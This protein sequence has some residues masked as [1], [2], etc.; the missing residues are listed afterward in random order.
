MARVEKT[1]QITLGEKT[2]NAV[3]A[4]TS[5]EKQALKGFANL[6]FQDDKGATLSFFSDLQIISKKDGTL[7]VNEPAKNTKND[8]G[9]WESHKYYLLEKSWKDLVIESVNELNKKSL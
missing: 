2:V 6:S 8:Q 4:F 3:V 1:T 5:Y 9:E 7:F